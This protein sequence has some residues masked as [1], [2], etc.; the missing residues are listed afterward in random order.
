M[1]RYI[2]C[3]GCDFILLAS[4]AERPR[5]ERHR[6]CPGCDGT[7]FRFESDELTAIEEESVSRK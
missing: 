3:E 1:D 6:T 5:P 7:D 4:N 2:R